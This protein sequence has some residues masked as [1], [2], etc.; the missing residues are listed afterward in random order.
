MC[1]KFNLNKYISAFLDSNKS[2]LEKWE[3]KDNQN[4]LNKL[5]KDKNKPKAASS[6]YIFFCKDK[7]NREKIK[8]DYPDL[9]S[10]D[11]SVEMGK[12]WKELSDTKKQKYKDQYEE[13]KQRYENEMKEYVPQE[14]SYEEL[15]TEKKQKKAT[16]LKNAKTAFQFFFDEMKT[17]KEKFEG[18]SATEI[19]SVITETWKQVKGSDEADKYKDM[20][21]EDK[22]R[23]ETAKKNKAE[24][25]KKKDSDEEEESNEEEQVKEQVVKEKS[26]EKVEPKKQ[27]SKLVAKVKKSI[28][29]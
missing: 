3:G 14:G 7:K 15:I 22:Q 17:D 26:K 16:G 12:M 1:S 8:T 10:Q 2:L 19:M 28:G 24:V 5:F 9:S 4:N 29:R 27:K 23:F 6:A 11:V 13:D 25:S 20:E 18:M 21:K